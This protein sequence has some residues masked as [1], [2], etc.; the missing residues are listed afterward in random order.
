MQL[1]F[2]VGLFGYMRTLLGMHHTV[3]KA[4]LGLAVWSTCY[5]IANSPGP[6]NRKRRQQ[7]AGMLIRVYNC[8]FIRLFLE[9]ETQTRDGPDGKFVR[10][11]D[12]RKMGTF[13]P[14]CY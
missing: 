5:R 9:W 1:F 7:H 12:R 3:L 11:H 13:L 2:C 6:D 14:C 10:H 8:A 4:P